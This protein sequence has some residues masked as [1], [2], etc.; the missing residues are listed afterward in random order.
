[1]IVGRSSECHE[2]LRLRGSAECGRGA[3]RVLSGAPGTGKSALL[4][5]TAE[6]AGAARVVTVECREHDHGR[7]FALLGAVIVALAV[8]PTLLLADQAATLRSVVDGSPTGAFDVVG[9]GAALV[10]LLAAAARERP[11]VLLVDDAD[12]ADDSSREVLTFAAQR[13]AHEPVLMLLAERDCD[14]NGFARHLPTLRVGGLSPLDAALL[15]AGDV[16]TR[17][18]EELGHATDGNPLALLEIAAQLSPEQRRGDA[19]LAPVLPIGEVVRGKFLARTEGFGPN[20]SRA[21]LLAAADPRIDRATL[22]LAAAAWGLDPDAIEHIVMPG[23]LDVEPSGAIRFAHPLLRVTVYESATAADRRAAHA[24]LGAVLSD[25]D[26]I[27]R[28]ARHLAAAADGPDERAAEA[29]AAAAVHNRVDRLVAGET[30]RRSA[31]LSPDPALRYERLVAAG[32]AFA[33]A[34]ENARAVSAFDDALVLTDDAAKRADILMRRALPAIESSGTSGVRE[35]LEDA[36][37]KLGASDPRSSVLIALAGVV[38]M[39]EADFVAARDLQ[40]F[41]AA[42]ESEATRIMLAISRL[43]MGDVTD[44]DAVASYAEELAADPDASLGDREFV[45]FA[46]TWAGEHSAASRLVDALVTRGRAAGSG[47]RLAFALAARAHLYFRIGHW[48][49]ARADATE[50]VELVA[51]ARHPSGLARSLFVLARVEAGFGNTAEAVADARRSYDMSERLAL[52]ALSWHAAG[53]L[54][55]AFL[56]DGRP[57]EAIEWLERAHEFARARQLRLL[58]TNLWAPDLVEAYLR[59]GRKDAAAG[60]VAELSDADPARQGALAHAVFLRCR[61]LVAADRGGPDFEAALARH[62]EVRAPFEEARTRLCHGEHLRR[63]RNVSA[64]YLCLTAAAEEFD[65]L[66]ARA[67]RRRALMEAAACARGRGSAATPKRSNALT[68][69]EHRVAIAVAAGATSREAAASLFLS[70]RTVEYHLAKIYR[71]LGLRSRTELVRRVA[72]DPEF[73]PPV[74]LPD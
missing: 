23:L 49:A 56:G 36:V 32:S 30:W 38:A 34:G 72:S 68:P 3:A 24:A 55:F 28:R 71:K 25:R 48:G 6:N 74:D 21:L 43:V 2:I 5:W 69:Q 19:P 26:E 4:R 22:G 45:V 58:T 17:V 39:L 12:R 37:T 63:E 67:W 7:A 27:E 50:S 29:L 14:P 8:D 46:L 65:R 52:G 41:A 10:S 66:G 35:Q 64:A 44:V 9:L 73:A 51:D 53:A 59:C 11:L 47:G 70:P 31:A 18:A 62:T 1:M 20:E 42:S 40:R 13:I 33:G 60:L 61:A 16:D 15:L 57:G 54:G